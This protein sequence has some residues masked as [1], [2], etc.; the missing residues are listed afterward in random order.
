MNRTS[1][2]ITDG[3]GRITDG[4][5]VRRMPM[6]AR[7]TAGVVVAA[8]MVTSIA[9]AQPSP[10]PPPLAPAPRAD[11]PAATPQAPP[12]LPP[13]T[14]GTLKQSAAGAEARA[15][16]PTPSRWQEDMNR[17]D[18]DLRLRLLAPN[19]PRTDWLAG[20][21]ETADIE[22][23]V[24]HF[25]AART[26]APQEALYQASLAI[27]CL[28]RVRPPLAECEAIDRLADWARR[29]A[30]N[31]VPSLLLAERAR[32]RG[33][34]DAAASH[35]EQASAA[36]RFDDYWSQAPRHWWDYLRALPIDVD[37]AARARAAANYASMHDLMWASS[38]RALCADPGARS[39]RM[40]T[41]CA[42]LGTSLMTRGATFALQRAG[43]RIAETNAADQ[44]ARSAAQSRHAR[45]LQATAR[46]AAVQPD[47][48]AALE[49]PVTPTRARGVEQFGDWASAQARDGEVLACERLST[50]K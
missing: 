45:I 49:S 48:T 19:E 6:N 34:L 43:A 37:T 22:T 38:L 26:S 27:A 40:K 9:L 44:R 11:T 36:A 17:L 7:R 23:Q 24:R 16:E 50:G 10:A 14:P 46:C 31:G 20:E 1:G 13:A 12:P 33:E 41:A 30:D 29:D 39:A 42:Q 21:L 47:F 8:A 5:H 2:R 35:V 4:A 25:T 18:A 3:A 32:Q 28:T 15:G